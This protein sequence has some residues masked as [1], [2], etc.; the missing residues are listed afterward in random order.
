M[1]RSLRWRLLAWQVVI[2]LVVIVGFGG[3]LYVEMRR[4]RLDEVDGELFAGARVLEGT[5]R[6]L[7]PEGRPPFPPLHAPPP[8]PPPPPGQHRPPPGRPRPPRERISPPDDARHPLDAPD[9]R[10]PP[11][12]QGEP[13]PEAWDTPPGPRGE[14]RPPQPGPPRDGPGL[15][16]LASVLRLPPSL[17][18]GEERAREGSPG[19][20]DERPRTPAY[21]V[22]W[23]PDGSV[24]A[25]SL[26]PD[27]LPDPPEHLNPDRQTD[28]WRR[29]TAREVAVLGPGRTRILVGRSIEPELRELDG[30]AIRLVLT[31]AAVFALGLV[32]GWWLSG[33]AIGPIQDI[34]ATAATVTASSLSRRV[35]VAHLD[36]ELGQLGTILNGMLARLEAAFAR[37]VEFTADASHE[38]RTPLAVIQT[39]AE[40]ALARPRSSAEYQRSLEACLR[41]AR[42]MKGIVEDLLLLAR[43]DSNK[44]ELRREPVDLLTVVRQCAALLE[45]LAAERKVHFRLEGSP[46]VVEADPEGI[47]RLVTNL[48]H[49]AVMHSKPEGTVTATVSQGDGTAQVAIADQ[50][51]G[52]AREHL[53]LLFERFYRVDKARARDSGGAGLGLAI[54]K[55][56][57]ET[58]GGTIAVASQVHGGSTF[59]LEL[60]RGAL[61]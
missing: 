47:T 50:G 4:A 41:A 17:E 32:G 49:N 15:A 60:Q 7:A 53:P 34:S 54:C 44:L 45:P 22:V 5:L 13:L 55:S 31:G 35:D 21:F 26:E 6:V 52:I 8:P 40:L 51:E 61:A 33:R 12:D 36:S 19:P 27:E 10:G 28:A 48:M 3:S 37:Q 39:Q 46:V 29:E 58:H 38:L 24:L 1:F 59:T 16:T 57:A 9:D 23:R 11:W 43:A 20:R 2:L 14:H 18:R 30:L 42:R 56:I 25:T